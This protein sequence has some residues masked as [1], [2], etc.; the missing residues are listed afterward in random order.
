[1]LRTL[2][3]ACLTLV[4]VVVVLLVVGYASLNGLF[5][6]AATPGGFEATLAARTRSLAIPSDARTA[7]N[8]FAPQKEAWRDALAHY[9]EH[10]ESCHGYD[11]HGGG[12]IGRNLEPKPP[13]MAQARTQ[14][15]TDGELFY[16]IQH[17]VRRTGMPAWKG[18]HTI[19]E[20]WKLVSFIRRIPLLTAEDMR[21]VVLASGHE[22]GHEADE[23][24][25]DDHQEH[26]H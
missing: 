14:Q 18:E 9:A 12:R 6:G 1:M 15:L 26:V 21:Q 17:G 8:P 24:H 25:D 5:F 3:D 19:E 4:V 11:G 7:R 13:D 2:R 20:S 10:C 16:I 23:H 22:H